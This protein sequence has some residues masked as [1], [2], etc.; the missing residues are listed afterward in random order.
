M[1]HLPR[2]DSYYRYV[3]HFYPD[4]DWPG[5]GG[6]H[7]RVGYHHMVLAAVDQTNLECTVAHELTHAVLDHLLLPLWLEEGLTQTMERRLSRYSPP[8]TRDD[9]EKLVRCWRTL[10]IELFWS[11]LSWQ[12]PG[13]PNEASYRL[14]LLLVDTLL[15]RHG[16]K[17]FQAF[18][19]DAD[20]ADAGEAAALRH[21]GRSLADPMAELL[22]PGDWAPRAL[23]TP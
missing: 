14:A 3:S 5:S 6:M 23:P 15:G 18:V 7:L 19:L 16:G 11:G 4:G 2:Q 17:P 22:G 1:I 13:E 10:G 9:A 8:F 12:M 21:L 20:P